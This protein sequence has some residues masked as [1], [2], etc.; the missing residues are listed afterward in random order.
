MPVDDLQPAQQPTSITA[1]P[2][3]PSP[4]SVENAADKPAVPTTGI[5]EGALDRPPVAL[6]PLPAPPAGLPAAPDA[7]ETGQ[8]VFA[9]LVLAFLALLLALEVALFPVSNSDTFGHLAS[10]RDLLAGKYNPFTGHD[11]YSYTTAGGW[12]NHSWLYGV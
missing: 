8:I 6:A 10:G 12:V 7:P 5:Q 3:A 4:G 9:D 11:P 2:T 1:E